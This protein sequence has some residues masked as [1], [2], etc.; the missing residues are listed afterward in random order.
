MLTIG[1]IHVLAMKRCIFGAIQCDVT[2]V[3][4]M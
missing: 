2:D 1:F 4:T 3:Y